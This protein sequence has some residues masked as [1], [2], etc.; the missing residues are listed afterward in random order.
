MYLEPLQTGGSFLLV[1]EKRAG[2]QPSDQKSLLGN[3]S[4]DAS[5]MRNAINVGT[6]DLVQTN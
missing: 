4:I 6:I 1:E 5:T 2:S 3:S